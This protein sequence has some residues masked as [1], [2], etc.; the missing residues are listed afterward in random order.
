MANALV[1]KVVFDE[2]IGMSVTIKVLGFVEYH[3]IYHI[4]CISVKVERSLN[5][6]VCEELVA[7]EHFCITFSNHVKYVYLI[8]IQEWT[9]L[10]LCVCWNVYYLFPFSNHSFN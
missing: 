9:C 1:Q 7:V 6:I 10:L 2:C 3:N 8:K 5:V 4:D